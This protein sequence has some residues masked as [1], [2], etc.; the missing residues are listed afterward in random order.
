MKIII[1]IIFTFSIFENFTAQEKII[2]PDS[3]KSDIVDIYF[4]VEVADPY[5]WMEEF[6][7][8]E[9]S[10][11]V[12]KQ[13]E[14]TE[15][16]LSQIEFRDDIRNDLVNLWDYPRYSSPFKAGDD[17]LFYK[18]DGLQPQ[19]VLYIL[20]EGKS[21][22]EVFID[23]NTFSDE[24][25][26]SL[27]GVFPSKDGKFISYSVSKSGS[28]WREFFV[29]ETSTGEKLKDHLKFIKF[30]G[31]NWFED[32]FF[33]SRYDSLAP[34]NKFTASN[35]SSKIYY[36]K[37]GTKQEEDVLVY[38]DTSNPK[39]SH[40]IFAS[41]DEEYLFLGKSTMGVRGNELYFKDLTQDNPE[42]Q[43]IFTGFGN[44]YSVVDK[45]G[46]DILIKTNEDAPNYKVIKL[47]P[48]FEKKHIIDVI[49][50]R[51]NPLKSV[52]SAGGKL[53]LIYMIDVSDVVYIADLNGDIL[54][55]LDTP[56]LGSVWGFGGKSYDTE[57][58]Y[59]FTSYIYPP[60][61]YRYDISSGSTSVYVK[62]DADINSEL[63]ESKRVFY[64]SKDGTMIP[65]FLTYK[66]G[67]ELNG[68][69]PV[70]L[71][72]YGGFNVSMLPSFNITNRVFWDNGGIYAVA[73][74]RGG[75]EYGREWH[76][77]GSKL[78]KQN[79][80]DD[81]IAAA[82]YLIKEKYTNP[83]KLAI[84]GG[85]NGGL[86]VGAVINQRPDLF[87]VAIPQ[88]GVMDMLRYHKFTIGWG[89]VTDYGS[90]D[91]PEMFECLYK[92]SPLHNIKSET[93]YPNIL[94]TT[95]EYDDR[96]VPAHSFKYTATLQEKL[97]EG[98]L[99]LLRVESKAG[100]GSG[101]PV[102]KYIDEQADIWAFVMY[103]LGISYKKVE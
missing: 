81:F 32:G 85:S 96:V 98:N 76:E 73:N 48:T 46:N 51:E 65:M 74:I 55:T 72:G 78:N 87:K 24:G 34:E 80:F 93:Q 26:V 82:E 22:P 49:P 69:N 16:Y 77:A 38:E 42:W 15:S 39:A 44:S 40:W 4:G 35:E 1:I 57:V 8:E 88:V 89:W 20:R 9:I 101:K 97:S 63:Y 2:Y 62:N 58:F 61:I 36:H 37:I 11:W 28:D 86:L 90:S 30:S 75:G 102:M 3:R 56:D 71:F 92:Y 83:D 43:P 41:E 33:Y 6:E 59:Q 54:Q 95:S 50:E 79:V 53:F 29:I 94:V 45:I 103:N 64:P 14:L 47:N 31:A 100:H 66:K 19:S 70:M 18:N 27:A 5:R 13:N 25:D 91:D 23:P 17:L 52:S 67:I 60:T 84:R 21:E 7:S 68:N 12:E 99:A 10:K